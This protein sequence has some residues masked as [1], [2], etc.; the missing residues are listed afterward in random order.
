MATKFGVNANKRQQTIPQLAE[1]SEVTGRLH[2]H[3][4]EYVTVGALAASDVILMGTLLP[5]GARVHSVLLDCPDLDSS[6]T[7][8]MSSG[9]Q[10]SADGV[11]A[12]SAAG[13]LAAQDVHTSGVAVSMS[14]SLVSVVPG[15][16]KK[17]ASA[18]QPILTIVAGPTTTVGATIRQTIHYTFD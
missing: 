11:E 4:D 10:A 12:A 7:A 2:V 13:F 8:T 3:Y 1:Q 14:A 16:F 5:A 18:V 9:W 17:F 6:T 15:K